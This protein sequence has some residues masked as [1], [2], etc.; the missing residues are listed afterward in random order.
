MKK[1][2]ILLILVVGVSLSFFACKKQDATTPLSN[3]FSLDATAAKYN[4][5]VRGTPT[6]QATAEVPVTWY[7][8]ALSMV[9]SVPGQAPGPISART[10]AYMGLS[11]YESVVPGMPRYQSLQSQLNGLPALPQVNTAEKYYYPASANASLASMLHYMLPNASQEQKTRIDSLENVFYT[12]FQSQVPQEVLDRSVNYGKTI[13]AAIYN[14]STSDGGAD[15]YLNLFPPYTPPAGPGLWQPQP[16]QSTLL[17]Y[18]GDVRP[19]IRGNTKSSQPPPPP[20]FSTNPNSFIYKEQMAVYRET[21]NQSD[22]HKECAL[23]WNAVP[24]SNASISIV[25]NILE[26]KAANLATAAEAYCKA[27]IAASDAQI[28]TWKTKFVYNQLRPIQYIRQY[29]DPN[30]SSFL[31]TPPFPDYTA[32]HT[33]QTAANATVLAALFG[34][35]VGSFTCDFINSRG[36][37]PRVF[38]SFTA[39]VADVARSRFYGGIHIYSSN[40][41]GILQGNRVGARVNALQCMKK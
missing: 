7:K 1:S 14:W 28:S 5:E 36:Y 41:V 6:A 29:I 13:A 22:E 17:P 33:V 38:N 24:G 31:P 12:S 11:L 8:F 35:N 18:W 25:T 39:Y 19:F 27:A 30:F 16:G 15:A 26:G 32:A 37:T 10:Y 20:P 23:Y 34:N 2:Q 21:M 40:G 4:A 9:L 3:Q